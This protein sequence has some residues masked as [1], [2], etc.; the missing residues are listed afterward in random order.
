MATGAGSGSE[1]FIAPGE[2]AL[3]PLVTPARGRGVFVNYRR[4]DTR[5]VAARVGEKLA[6]RLDESRVFLDVESI[7]PGRD[8]RVAVRE[9]IRHS[10]VM[11]VLIG[12]DWITAAR[13]DGI[14][15]LDDPDDHVRTEIEEGLRHD[16]VVIP[17]LVDGTPMPAADA[18][19]GTLAP[20]AACHAMR[21]D[22]HHF[23][24]DDAALIDV[25]AGLLAVEEP[26][27]SVAQTDRPG[28]VVNDQVIIV[29]AHGTANV[30]QGGNQ[31]FHGP[32]QDQ[33]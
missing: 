25:V 22:H 23:R 5:H 32:A 1:H 26:P 14:R 19:P 15:R 6:T 11:V 18:L 13:P 33:R 12:S 24:R 8:F 16:L 17:V 27:G 28:T 31:H 2:P 30:V 9:A 4:S 7:R 3:D 20:L 21:V 10:A 29:G